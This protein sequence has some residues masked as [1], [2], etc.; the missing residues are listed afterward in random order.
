MRPLTS[1]AA[2]PSR[3]TKLAYAERF[4]AALALLFLRQ[5]DAVG[6]VRF[7]ERVRAPFRL[8]RETDSGDA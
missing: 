1:E 4:T 6:L 5:R 7:D 3:L 2:D 8:G